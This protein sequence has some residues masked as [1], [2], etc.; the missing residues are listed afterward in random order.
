MRRLLL[1]AAAIAAVVIA[2]PARAGQTN[3]QLNVTATVAASCMIAAP[4]L[5]FGAYDGTQNNTAS[6]RITVTCNVTSHPVSVT[7]NTGLHPA[8]AIRQMANGT[9]NLQYLLFTDPARTVAWNN[10]VSGTG[11]TTDTATPPT[12]GIDLYGRIPADQFVNVQGAFNDTV[13][14]TV[15][16]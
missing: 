8:G 9:Q 1:A 11:L 10:A 5:A 14:M 16:F 7:L 6:T 13:V 4:D 3:G 15:T 2:A 12:A